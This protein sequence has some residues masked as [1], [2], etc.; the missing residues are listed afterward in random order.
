MTD[1]GDE[2]PVE[3]TARRLR[4]QA[5]GCALIGSPLYAA[6]LEDAADD[7]IA[8]GPTLRV[9]EDHLHDPGPSALALRMLGGIHALVLTGQAPD[10]ARYYPSASG[11]VPVDADAWPALAA[12]L[13]DH[14]ATVRD[15]LLR[16]PQTNEVGRGAALIGGLLHA[17]TEAE[18][19]VRLVEIGTSAGLNLRADRFHITGAVA[20]YGDLDSP[21]HLG[22][23]W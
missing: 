9:L 17:V 11:T 18:L 3:R 12:V 4:E 14:R 20:S 21:V 22:A 8:G 19:P 7:L 16:P 13:E 2:S 23:A 1:D 10:L 5:A 15:W 6:L